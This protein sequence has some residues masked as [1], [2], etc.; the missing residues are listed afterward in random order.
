MHSRLTD[1]AKLLEPQHNNDSL[2]NGNYSD[3][4]FLK[5]ECEI[6]HPYFTS[7]DMSHLDLKIKVEVEGEFKFDQKM[8][9]CVPHG[10]CEISYVHKEDEEEEGDEKQH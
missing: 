8:Q 7:E 1:I 4:R 10:M 3:F 5:R 9:K 6:V 2:S